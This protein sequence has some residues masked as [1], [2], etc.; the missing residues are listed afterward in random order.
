MEIWEIGR[1]R[2]FRDLIG[3]GEVL[4]FSLSAKRFQDIED[5]FIYFTVGTDTILDNSIQHR[6]V[7][8]KHT[9]HSPFRTSAH[10]SFGTRML[11]PLVTPVACSVTSIK[12]F[13]FNFTIMGVSLTIPLKIL[14]HSHFLPVLISLLCIILL[15]IIYHHI[16]NYI[17]YFIYCLS[18]PID[19]N[20]YEGKT[21]THCYIL[22]LYLAHKDSR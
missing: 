6:F 8:F 3:N 5:S 10:T 13:F 11:S 18:L 1:A 22:A 14:H 16:V 7:F 21:W 9:K 2:S 17:T 4:G 15:Y 12:V 20:I 19:G